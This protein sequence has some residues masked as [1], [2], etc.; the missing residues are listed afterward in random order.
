MNRIRMLLRER[1]RL[2][3]GRPVVA[4][5]QS[6]QAVIEMGLVMIVLMTLTF[7]MVDFGFFL[8]GYI[9]ASNCAREVARAAVIRS[10][11]AATVCGT[12]QLTPI[13][14]SATV[15]IGP[16]GYLTETAGTPVTATVTGVYRWKAIAPLINAFYPGGTL[17]NPTITTTHTATMRLEGRKL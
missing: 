2:R 8:T 1:P 9:R 12:D 13:F 17:W 5:R 14:E 3:R 10:T 11:G 6:G 16:S 15:A 7:G 4:R